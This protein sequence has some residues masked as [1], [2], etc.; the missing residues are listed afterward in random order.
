MAEV[1][2]RVFMKTSA[3]AVTASV[4]TPAETETTEQQDMSESNALLAGIAVR[5]II[6]EAGLPMWGY[7]DRPGVSTGTLDPLHAKCIVFRAGTDSLALVTMD[8]GRVP[9]ESA[10][11]RI[12]DRARQAGVGHVVFTASHTHH[13]PVMEAEDAPH[14]RAI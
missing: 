4:V 13:G 3:A 10:R 1:T 8:L 5:D 12:Q 7:S 11:N 14:A 9:T 2:R 6:A